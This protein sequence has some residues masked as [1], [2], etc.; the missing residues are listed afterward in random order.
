MRLVWK[1]GRV[2]EGGRTGEPAWSDVGV[3][4]VGV[5]LEVGLR[6]KVWKLEEGGRVD[7]LVGK[8]VVVVGV[9]L[10]RKVCWTTTLVLIVM[11][12]FGR[13]IFYVF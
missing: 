3:G 10:S 7:G 1:R 13:D 12:G 8:V 5:R 2:G 11:L 4:G 9:G 6:R